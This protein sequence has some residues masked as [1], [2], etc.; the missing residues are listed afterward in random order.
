MFGL[1]Q[2]KYFIFPKKYLKT[3]LPAIIK[4][5]PGKTKSDAAISNSFYVSFNSKAAEQEN[6]NAQFAVEN[7][8]DNGKGVEKNPVKSKYWINK[9]LTS[10][11]SIS[12]DNL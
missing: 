4:M 5:S 8:Y 11:S 2:L 10:R 9:A 3:L 12:S 6:S 7:M 1:I